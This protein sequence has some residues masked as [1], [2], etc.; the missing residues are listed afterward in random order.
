MFFLGTCAT[1]QSYRFVTPGLLILEGIIRKRKK[2]HITH[3]HTMA[4]VCN[5]P[6]RIG[7]YHGNVDFVLFV[8]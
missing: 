4:F 6:T 7:F 5:P 8:T 2:I 3:H 1:L